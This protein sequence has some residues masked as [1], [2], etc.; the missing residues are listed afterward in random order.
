MAVPPIAPFGMHHLAIQCRDLPR[1]VRFYE[2]VLRLQV[3]R[4]WP[5]E[6]PE[7]RGADRSVWLRL[8]TGVLALEACSGEPTPPEWQS[9]QAGFHLLALEIAWQNRAVWL[10]HLALHQVEVV[11]Q[12]PWTIYVRD[13]EGNRVGLSHFPYDAAGQPLV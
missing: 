6:R 5:S 3:A 11:H 7:D 10:G 4:R 12:S 1:M 13:P 9:D 2:R 8:G